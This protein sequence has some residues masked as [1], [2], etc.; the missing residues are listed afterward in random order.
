MKIAKNAQFMPTEEGYE[1]WI[2]VGFIM[3]LAF[4]FKFLTLR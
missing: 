3:V 4:A 1:F 2:M